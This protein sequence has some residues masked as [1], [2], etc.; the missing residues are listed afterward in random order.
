MQRENRQRICKQAQKGAPNFAEIQYNNGHGNHM[1]SCLAQLCCDQTHPALT[2]CQAEPALHFHT[3]TFIPIV[4]SHVPDFTLLWLPQCRTGEPDAMH[5]R[6]LDHDVHFGKG[7]L[8]LYLFSEYCG[9]ICL[10]Q[11]HTLKG[12]CHPDKNKR[13]AET[14]NDLRRCNQHLRICNAGQGGQRS[15][16]QNSRQCGENGQH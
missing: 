10:Q 15:Q 3:F 4:L 11:P 14:E 2:L 16:K 7:T 6:K 5:L 9:R 12:C 13:V 1:V 8:T